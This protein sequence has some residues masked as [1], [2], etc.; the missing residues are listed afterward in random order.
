[1]T[2]RSFW[3]PRA[4][5]GL[6]DHHAV[7]L[8]AACF[9]M[10]RCSLHFFFLAMEEAIVTANQNREEKS[11]LIPD[12]MTGNGTSYKEEGDLRIRISKEHLSD[13]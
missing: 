1:M 6:E 3:K 2:S 9:F 5:C 13:A 8:H 7:L 4:V 10:L 12:C 11:V